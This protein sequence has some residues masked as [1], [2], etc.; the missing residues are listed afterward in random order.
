[1]ADV[2]PKHSKYPE[3]LIVA[4]LSFPLN[5]AVT[6]HYAVLYCLVLAHC[7]TKHKI[8]QDAAQALQVKI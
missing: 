1:M 6:L 3:W 4:E 2:T 8:R 5:L 7:V